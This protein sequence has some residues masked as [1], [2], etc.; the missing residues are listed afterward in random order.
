LDQPR[1][2]RSLVS[3]NIIPMP[4]VP[5]VEAARRIFVLL[6]ASYIATVTAACCSTVRLR[7]LISAVVASL[8]TCS[9]LLHLFGYKVTI[10]D[11]KHF[12]VG[13]NQ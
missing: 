5:C 1:S 12:R 4:W 2:F 3:H 7:V 9:A 13:N 6:T 8:L 10:D 11:L